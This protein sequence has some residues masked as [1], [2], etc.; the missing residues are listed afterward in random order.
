MT[1]V[2]LIRMDVFGAAHGREGPKWLPCLKASDS[3][4]LPNKDSRN[5]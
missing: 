3:Y 5:I 4:T 2:N 1:Y